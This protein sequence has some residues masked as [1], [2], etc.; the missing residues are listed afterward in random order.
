MF[1]HSFSVRLSELDT[2]GKIQPYHIISYFQDAA[3][4]YLQQIGM[5]GFDLAKTNQ[6]WVV[7][8]MSV[9]FETPLPEWN[10]SVE[11]TTWALNRTG[12]RLFRDFTAK[13]SS[14]RFLA[15][16]PSSWV[17]ID[18]TS[19]QPVA[20]DHFEG[21]ELIIDQPILPGVKPGRFSQIDEENITDRF[22]YIWRPRT[23]EQDLNRH[24]NNINYL[25]SC[26]ESIPSEFRQSKNLKRV[27][28][29]FKAEIY[30]RQEIEIQ[31]VWNGT[32]AVHRLIRTADGFEVCT[33]KT[34]WQNF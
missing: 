7:N 5:S 20:Q 32:E 29:V 14:G 13:D 22:S 19:R 34:F 11:I 24:I 15:R 8:A 2:H 33:A 17:I 16:G 6:G 12:V 26:I 23:S 18:E 9:L 1:T 27:D 3:S 21:K 30:A 4:I 31:T 10:E 28:I 25:I